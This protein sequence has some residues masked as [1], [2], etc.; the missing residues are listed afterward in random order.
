MTTCHRSLSDTASGGLHGARYSNPD[1]VGLRNPLFTGCPSS[2]RPKALSKLLNGPSINTFVW[3]KL[4]QNLVR[5][6]FL[7]RKV[8]FYTVFV[9]ECVRIFFDDTCIY[10][11]PVPENA[12]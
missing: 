4:S 1:A 10:K 8:Y 3:I 6:R 9:A 5:A 7:D 11:S 12:K 2:L